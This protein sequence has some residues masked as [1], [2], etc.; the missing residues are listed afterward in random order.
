MRK[1]INF[2]RRE[3]AELFADVFKS[4]KSLR[5]CGVFDYLAG[6]LKHADKEKCLMHHR[7]PT[8]LP[9]MQ[10][11]AVYDGGRFVYWRYVVCLQKSDTNWE[12][13]MSGKCLAHF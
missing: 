6:H 4:L 1:I 13:C 10:P 8:D 9:E 7:N 5:L 3:L 2:M 12:C 11:L